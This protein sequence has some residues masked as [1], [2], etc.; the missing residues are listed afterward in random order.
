M[1]QNHQVHTSCHNSAMYSASSKLPHSATSRSDLHL[2]SDQ[3]HSI[4]KDFGSQKSIH[5]STLETSIN[6]SFMIQ[7]PSFRGTELDLQRQP[8]TDS[9]NLTTDGLLRHRLRSNI[10]QLALLHTHPYQGIFLAVGTDDLHVYEILIDYSEVDAV[11]EQLTVILDRT[12]GDTVEN[13]QERGETY[14]IVSL[15]EHDRDQN[16]GVVSLIYGVEEVGKWGKEVLIIC[17]VLLISGCLLSFIWKDAI[18]DGLVY[19]RRVVSWGCFFNVWVLVLSQGK[20]F[21]GCFDDLGVD[22]CEIINDDGLQVQGMRLGLMLFKCSLWESIGSWFISAGCLGGVVEELQDG[23][24]LVDEYVLSIVIG[25]GGRFNLGIC[26]DCLSV[27]RHR[28]WSWGKGV[29]DVRMG[30]VVGWDAR[31]VTYVQIKG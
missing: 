9:L 23:T 25:N 3:C 17:Y 13:A 22:E 16:V 30:L 15:L 19:G 24:L 5:N 28:C 11:H 27:Y 14:L 10:L 29:D 21:T 8:F 18:G 4:A 7:A 2:T 26:F 31:Y 20:I 6:M 12:I 1:S